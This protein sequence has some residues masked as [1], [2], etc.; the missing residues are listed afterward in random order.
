MSAEQYMRQQQKKT[1]HKNEWKKRKSLYFAPAARVCLTSPSLRL[2]LCSKLRE[3]GTTRNHRHRTNYYSF[4]LLYWK[5]E[6]VTLEPGH[7]FEKLGTWTG[8]E[9]YTKALEFR[10]CK[11]LREVFKKCLK[12]LLL[13]FDGIQIP[14]QI[15]LWL[16]VILLLKE[17]FILNVA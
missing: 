5:C 2:F 1:P 3:K 4:A 14:F 12:I 8:N 11:Y 13:T 9:W 6:T 16:K 7:T 10:N 15:L 17:V